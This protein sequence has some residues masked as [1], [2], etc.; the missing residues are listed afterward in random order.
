[1]LVFY[2]DKILYKAFKKKWKLD[3]DFNLDQYKLPKVTKK[4]VIDNE[5]VLFKHPSHYNHSKYYQYNMAISGYFTALFGI[6]SYIGLKLLIKKKTIMGFLVFS[7]ISLMSLLEARITYN[8]ILDVKAITVANNGRILRVE[9]F[10]NEKIKYDIDLKDFRRIN[11]S[12]ELMV[13]IDKNHAKEKH[14]RFFFLEPTSATIYNRELFD[15]VFVDNRYV[16]L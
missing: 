14:F 7:G 2:F 5:L 6:T 13:F 10:Q 15:I 3:E 1:M 11:K 4:I 16:L 9:T 12:K 8:R